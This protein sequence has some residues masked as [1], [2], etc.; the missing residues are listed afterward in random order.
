M[1]KFFSTY[2]PTYFSA[3]ALLVFTFISNS[4]GQFTE[5]TGFGG[6]MLGETFNSVSAHEVYI[7]DGAAYGGSF[8]FYPEE[9]YDIALTYVRQS[10]KLDFYDYYSSD[11]A[12]NVPVSVNYIMI[13][14]DRN[15]VL[16]ANGTS[17]FGGLNL[18]TVG[19][20]AKDSYY[21]GV[22]KFAFDVHVGAKIFVTEVVG[23]RLQAGIN[24]PVQ[25]FGAAFSLGGAGANASVG[26]TGSV[27]QVNFLGGLIFRLP[28]KS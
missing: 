27:T 6:Y 17:V 18:G 10:T 26:A 4:Y 21:K 11:F 8:A 9:H 16:S 7:H 19:L 28:G 24:F 1:K 12:E 25:Y 20:E 3:S 2:F 22:W 14:G 15:Q 5:I 23:I 13:G